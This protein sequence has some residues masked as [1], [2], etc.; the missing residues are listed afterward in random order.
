MQSVQK[1][2]IFFTRRRRI[3]I[4]AAIV[5][6]IS[7]CIV[8]TIS[9][10]K[11]TSLKFTVIKRKPL[12]KVH[13]RFHAQGSSFKNSTVP[14]YVPSFNLS[15]LTEDVTVVTAYFNLGSFVKGMSDVYGTKLYH[16]WMTVFARITNPVVFYVDTDN[17]ANLFS[18]I[19][20][21]Q[22]KNRTRI[23]R[24]DRKDLW[25]FSLVPYIEEIYNQPYFPKHHPNTVR[26]DYSAAMHAKYELIHRTIHRNPFQTKY[27]SWLDIGLF[28]G[29]VPAT[30]TPSVPGGPP[31][32]LDLPQNLGSDKIGYTEVYRRDSSLDLGQI[33]S[34][35][36]VWICGCF[37]IGRV[38]VMFRWVVEYMSAVEQ[39]IGEHWMSTDQQVIY[40]IYNKG[41]HSTLIQTFVSENDYYNSWFYL[42]YLSRHEIGSR[43]P[44]AETNNEENVFR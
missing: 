26:P 43:K 6:S 17:E 40:W 7:L 33:I 2:R 37:F 27:I 16:H 32:H 34:G 39:M 4:A 8:S 38:D 25:S 31:F 12:K 22:P 1:M 41:L 18:I 10:R 11:E 36:Y 35:N 44:W 20:S 21:H 24:V 29:L 23:V 9:A 3:L 15:T 13:V 14:Q 28:R 19:R 30:A 42:G 5:T